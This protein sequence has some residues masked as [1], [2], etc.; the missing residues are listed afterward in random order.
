MKDM[1]GKNKQAQI[2]ILQEK[3]KKILKKIRNWKAPG[4]DRVQGFWLKN[5]TSLH[6]NLVW[7][8]NACLEG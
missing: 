5:S 1:N 4:T 7:Y 3:L 2:K 8:L 6:K